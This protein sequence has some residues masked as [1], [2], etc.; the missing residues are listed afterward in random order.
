MST[1]VKNFACGKLKNKLKEL[2]KITSYYAAWIFKFSFFGGFS[3]KYIY[4]LAGN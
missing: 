1:G 4:N 3:F 2:I